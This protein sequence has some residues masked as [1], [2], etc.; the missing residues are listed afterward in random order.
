[1]NEVTQLLLSA[2]KLRGAAMYLG[3]LLS[4]F[5]C[6]LQTE[7]FGQDYPSKPIRLIIPNSPG[8][9]QDLAARI[10]GPEMAKLLGQPVIVENKPGANQTIGLEYVAKQMPADGYTLTLVPVG[11]LAT[12]PLILKELRFDPLQDLPPVMGVFETRLALAVPSER[13][14]KTL[15]ELAMYAKANPGKLNYGT[16]TPILTLMTAALLR[17]MGVT[18]VEV[19][20]SGGGPMVN[21]L[22]AGTIDMAMIGASN[23]VS[24]AKRLRTLVQTGE[25]RADTLAEAPTFA[26]LGYPEL[27]SV[28]N[29]LHMRAGTPKAVTERIFTALSRILQQP[30]VRAAMTKSQF[31]IAMRSADEVAAVLASDAKYF[32]DVAKVIGLQPQ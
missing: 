22:M 8:L 3:L 27:R 23:A 21:A 13:P 1:M 7:V 10:L 17:K 15:N 6:L 20:F 26:E 24:A 19:P 29:S 32:A 18:I 5:A 2:R 14:W 30:E 28:L 25:K 12:L 11:H 16:A 4:G 9:S 31:E